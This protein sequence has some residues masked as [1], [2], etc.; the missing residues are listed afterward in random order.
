MDVFPVE[1]ASNKKTFHS[2]LQDLD[3]VILT[4]HVGGSPEEAQER[5]GTEVARKLI[6][7]SDVGTTVGAVNFPQVQLPARPTGTRYIH[8][9][10]NVPGMLGH[11]TPQAT[12]LP[13]RL[14]GSQGQW[15]R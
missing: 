5:I 3:N 6:D 14:M 12:Q 8:V 4:P 2:P 15:Q 13:R 10:R 9:Y 7:Y 1:P 11:F